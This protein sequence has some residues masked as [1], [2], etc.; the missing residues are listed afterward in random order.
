VSATLLLIS[1]RVSLFYKHSTVH[2]IPARE[3]PEISFDTQICVF[4]DARKTIKRIFSFR[5]TD[6]FGKVQF[7]PFLGL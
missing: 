1:R 4:D 6:I 5:N 3:I 2:I 7:D